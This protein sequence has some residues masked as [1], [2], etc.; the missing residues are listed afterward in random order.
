[1]KRSREAS[2]RRASASASAHCSCQPL[3]FD[4]LRA[5][6][7][8]PQLQSCVCGPPCT[9]KLWKIQGK[10]G[11]HTS[12]TFS[13]DA[14]KASRTHFRDKC[15]DWQSRRFIWGAVIIKCRETAKNREL[16]HYFLQFVLQKN[17]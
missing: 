16:I 12:L 15:Q 8:L 13:V 7:R 4:P 17:V 1:M 9:N 2:P 10:N 11:K 6:D 3:L 14:G 5:P